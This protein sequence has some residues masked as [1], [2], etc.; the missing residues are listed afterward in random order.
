VF[1][2]VQGDKV[3]VDAILEHPHIAAVSFVGSTPIAKYI[4]QQGVAHGKRVQALGGAKNHAVIMPDADLDAACE[5]VTGAAFGSAG[6]R[7]MA[8]SV[9]VAVGDAAA[10]G[11][12][13]RLE[14]RIA[15][16]KVGAPEAPGVDMGPLVTEAAQARVQGYIDA[17]VAAG[18][19]LC[20]DGRGVHVADRPDGYYV[21]PT[22][23]DRV[24]SDMSVYRDEIFGPVLSVVRVADYAAAM[25]LVNGHEFANGTVILTQS[26]AVAKAFVRDVEVGMVGVNVPIPV[27]MAFPQ[28]RWVAPFARRRPPHA[29]PGRRAFL[30]APEDRDGALA[31]AEVGERRLRHADD[32]VRRKRRCG[33]WNG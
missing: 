2:V 26:G 5:A 6:E 23:F 19:T 3:A 12:I 18:A 24:T 15:K 10:D 13:A 31:R 29:W 9:V 16:L 33:G 14:K 32:E 1:N 30:H 4:Q 25:D 27:P 11:L 28:L 20:A 17:G 22:L 7:C 8:I 21:G